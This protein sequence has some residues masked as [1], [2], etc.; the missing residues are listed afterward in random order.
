MLALNLR[1]TFHAILAGLLLTTSVFGQT[2]PAKPIRLIVPYAPGGGADTHARSIAQKLSEALGQSVVVENR[3]GAD[4][5]IGTA[6]VARAPGNGY[7]GLIT[8]SSHAINPILY[9]KIA[10]DTVQDFSCV[11][12]TVAQQVILFVHPSLPVHSV[13]ELIQYA[14][15]NPTVLNFASPSKAT[16]LPM[17]LFNTMAGTKMTNIPYKGSGAAMTDMLAGRIQVGFGGTNSIAAVVKAGKLRALAVG[18]SQRSNFMPELPT[19]AEAGLPGF[20]SSVWTVFVVPSSTPRPIVRKLY[21]E[22]S[23]VLNAPEF[24]SLMDTQGFELVASTPEQCD[25]FIKTEIVK[26]AKVAKDA[27]IQPE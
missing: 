6:I 12:Q 10:F 2:Y 1:L 22:T 3:A 16:Q 21:E 14:K 5:M 17:G 13:K 8:G 15:A 7:T 18:G 27:G 9:S 20:N 11:T 25:A 4:G 23:R 24:K 19:V 26:W